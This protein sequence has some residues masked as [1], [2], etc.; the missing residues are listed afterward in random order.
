MTNAPGLTLAD[1]AAMSE[2]VPV[3]TSF[4]TVHGISAKNALAIFKRFPKL[5]S[6]INGFD[7][8]TFIDAAPEAVSAIIA[9]GTGHFGDEQAEADAGN[10]TIEV[11]FDILQAIGRLT[12][13]SGFGP[14]VERIMR[15]GGSVPDFASSGKAQ[16][17]KSPPPSSSSSPPDTPQT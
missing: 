7:L 14:F 17:T 6:L 16:D 2:D 4:I 8:G 9:A 3:G 5:L 15:L 1:L 11:Q 10:I 12:F 13:K